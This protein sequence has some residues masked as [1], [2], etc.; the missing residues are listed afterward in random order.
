MADKQPTGSF[1]FSLVGGG[2]A[3][4]DLSDYLFLR[5][6]EWHNTGRYAVAYQT[7]K[8]ILMHR[9]ILKAGEGQFVDH[10][11]SN[12]YNNRRDNIRL[13]TPGENVLNRRKLKAASSRFKGVHWAPEKR[14]WAAMIGAKGERKYLGLFDT[15]VEAARAYDVACRRMHGEFARTNADLQLY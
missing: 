13:C 7:N 3:W 2:H 4:C 8:T 9:L 1:R 10:I 15:E 12:G 6:H 11:D 5:A 14:R